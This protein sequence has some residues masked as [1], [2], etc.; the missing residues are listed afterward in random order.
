MHKGPGT[1]FKVNQGIYGY[2]YIYIIIYIQHNSSFFIIFS[3]FSISQPKLHPSP[4]HLTGALRALLGRRAALAEAG[5][6][7]GR[8]ALGDLGAF[9]G[10]ALVAAALHR[11][12]AVVRRSQV[13]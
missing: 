5:A 2:I 6:G 9:R 3:H 10:R 13:L 8:R 4:P 11:G 7:E 1:Q 12:D